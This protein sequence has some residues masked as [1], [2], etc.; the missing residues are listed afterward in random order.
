MANTHC[1]VQCLLFFPNKRCEKSEH[2]NDGRKGLL[3][4]AFTL[5][6]YPSSTSCSSFSSLDLWS[7]LAN[8][9]KTFPHSNNINSMF[10]VLF[11]SFFIHENE[12]IGPKGYEQIE[13]TFIFACCVSESSVNK[14]IYILFYG[15]LLLC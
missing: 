9:K 3:C 10:D 7:T 1:T 15:L 11:S 14:R 4:L 5:S 13:N 6:L 8:E 2:E 12:G